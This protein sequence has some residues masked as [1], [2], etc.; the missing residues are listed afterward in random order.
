MLQTK[1]INDM[2]YGLTE[3]EV[4][5]LESRHIYIRS[6]WC[7][8]TERVYWYCSSGNIMDEVTYYDSPREA[9]ENALYPKLPNWPDPSIMEMHHFMN[10]IFANCRRGYDVEAY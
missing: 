1:G 10:A 4:A 7:S 5:E 6:I 2:P 8:E 9:Y 3:E